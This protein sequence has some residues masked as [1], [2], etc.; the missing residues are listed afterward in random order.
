MQSCLAQLAVWMTVAS[1]C[2]AA[3]SPPRARS[4]YLEYKTIVKNLPSGVKRLELWIPVPRDDAHQQ[5]ANLRVETKLP[6]VI[7]HDSWGNKILHIVVEN[8]KDSALI[9]GIGF[10][11]TRLEHR[12]PRLYTGPRLA[13][14]EDSK[15]LR[16]WLRPVGWIPVDASEA[17][18]DP[19]RREYFFGVHDENRIEFTRGRDIVLS[20]RQKGDPLNYFIY[21][22]AEVDGKVFSGTESLVTY[23]DE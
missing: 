10:S 20:P 2:H 11:A 1:L 8:P 18:K 15:E 21:P 13:R 22:Y 9:A 5:I 4:F 16:R 6:Y 23:R 7:S 17:A 3:G 19:S 12:Q 14:E